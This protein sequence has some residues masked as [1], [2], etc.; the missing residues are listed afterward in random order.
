MLMYQDP[1]MKE[2]V[3]EFCKESRN[4]IKLLNDFLNNLEDDLS[5]VAQLESFGQVIDRMMGA[6]KSLQINTLGVLCELGKTIGY[7]ASQV[8]DENIISIVAAV[9]F[10]GVEIIEKFIIKLEKGDKLEVK[11][12]GM[13]AFISRLQWLNDKFK[14]I[15]RGSVAIESVPLKDNI[16][17]LLK[18]LGI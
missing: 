4:Q 2:I 10:D 8:D 3:Q 12:I 17:E 16:D 6:A 15:K 9:L 11:D 18:Q 13:D 1:E 5:D 7:K 14:H